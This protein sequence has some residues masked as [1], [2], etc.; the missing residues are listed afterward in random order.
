M[1]VDIKEI[2]AYI[3][4]NVDYEAVIPLDQLDEMLG[5]TLPKFGTISEIQSAQLARMAAI[6][7]LSG[8]LLKTHSL[9]LKN[10]RGEGYKIV[11]PGQQV[12][13]AMRDGTAKVVK[14]L[15]K[16]ARRVV[17]VRT[18]ELNPQQVAEQEDALNKLAGLRKLIK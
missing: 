6:E 5:V 7:H 9:M 12:S 16:A 18:Q 3:A 14:E 17:N 2:A 4:S 1:T 15:R 10:V 11:L 13:T 8:E